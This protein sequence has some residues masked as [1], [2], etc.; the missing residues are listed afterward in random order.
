ME[1]IGL[2]TDPAAAAYLRDAY[3]LKQD[4]AVADIPAFAAPDGERFVGGFK[5]IWSVIVG[6]PVHTLRE[7]E[8]WRTAHRVVTYSFVTQ[9]N[10][11]SS[12]RFDHLLEIPSGTPTANRLDLYARNV[13]KHIRNAVEP[14]VLRYTCEPTRHDWYELY[15]GAMAR[16]RHAPR[17]REW[18]ATLEQHFGD[19]TFIASAYDG[20][21]L[22]GALYCIRSDNYLQLLSIASDPSFRDV[23]IDSGLYD[24][25][26]RFAIEND[27]RYVDFGPTMQWDKS[28]WEVKENF[29]AKRMYF[30]DASFMPPIGRLRRAA[31]SLSQRLVSRATRLVRPVEGLRKKEVVRQHVGGAARRADERA[32]KAPTFPARSE[33]NR[34]AACGSRNSDQSAKVS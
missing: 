13:R 5:H 7:L 29:G 31:I 18:F 3:G 9:Q 26:I 20:D 4:T 27:I 6:D 12:T 21:R 33:A 24:T 14:S 16:H 22:V 15:L 28:H 30:A 32:G 10:G 2:A 17:P 1:I 19:R 8:S 23:R 34:S 11:F 25:A